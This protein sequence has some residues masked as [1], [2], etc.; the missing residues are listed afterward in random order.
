MAIL[1]WAICVITAIVAAF[2]LAYSQGTQLGA[3]IVGGLILLLW[4]LFVFGFLKVS[5]T[6]RSS[7]TVGFVPIGYLFCAAVCAVWL[8]GVWLKSEFPGLF[9][10]ANR[11][12]ESSA[13]VSNESHKLILRNF[14]N[15]TNG[16]EWN[17]NHN[18]RE[19]DAPV[20][21]WYGVSADSSG[22]VTKI[23]LRS[24][25]LHNNELQGNGL[26]DLCDI[27]SLQALDLSGNELSGGIPDCLLEEEMPTLKYL[28]LSDNDFT[29]APDALLDLEDTPPEMILIADITGNDGLVGSTKWKWAGDGVVVIIKGD[30]ITIPTTKAV[31]REARLSRIPDLPALLIVGYNLLRAGDDRIAMVNALGPVIGLDKLGDVDIDFYASGHMIR[32]VTIC[33]TSEGPFVSLDGTCVQ[34]PIDETTK[35]AQNETT[36]PK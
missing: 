7:V 8:G 4:V 20:Q 2:A 3:I 32:G 29:S 5:K 10:S 13:S 16:D 23:D 18:W 36:K 1:I 27:K 30:G 19:I 35:P 12:S 25:K 21:S 33:H 24:N 34:K 15:A 6:F 11:D 9:G 31:I 26:E 28:D 17:N 22:S 14:Y